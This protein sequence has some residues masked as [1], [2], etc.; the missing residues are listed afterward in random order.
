VPL[1][2]PGDTALTGEGRLYALNMFD[3]RV[4]CESVARLHLKDGSIKVHRLQQV[5]ENRTRC[6]PLVARAGALALCRRGA[7]GRV[8]FTT[9]D[10]SLRS[11]RAT[12]SELHTIVDI[13]DF[14]ANPP[15][16]DPFFHNAWIEAVPR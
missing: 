15:A 3:A 2:Q 8:P 5:T 10:L 1:L 4:V 11:R 14:C 9:L 13:P 7:I 6:D 12:D 16:Y